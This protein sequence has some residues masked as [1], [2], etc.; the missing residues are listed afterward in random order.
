M[1]PVRW[2]PPEAL[3]YRTFTVASDI[4]SYG[5]L[6]LEIFTYGRQPWFQLS[7]QEVREVLNIT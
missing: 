1:L 5:I 7:N 6:L 3:L 2:L 4:W